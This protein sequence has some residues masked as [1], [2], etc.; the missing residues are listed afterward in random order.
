MT[1]SSPPSCSARRFNL[2][3]SI[4][5]WLETELRTQ[6]VAVMEAVSVCKIP[7][8]SEVCTRPGRSML[9]AWMP[10]GA[11]LSRHQHP[12][13]GHLV[14]GHFRRRICDN[15]GEARLRDVVFPLQRLAQLLHGS[16]G[17]TGIRHRHHRFG[18]HGDGIVFQSAPGMHQT[19]FP[20]CGSRLQQTAQQHVR[21]GPALLIS[22]PEWPPVRPLTATRRQAPS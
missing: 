1:R 22:E 10:L 3:W 19:Q 13:R 2:L 14:H 5:F 15:N 11:Q 21:V 12:V 4:S 18:G 7:R 6:K 16:T 9:M 17:G 8:F 20:G